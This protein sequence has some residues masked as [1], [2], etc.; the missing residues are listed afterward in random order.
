MD[1]LFDRCRVLLDV[2]GVTMEELWLSFFA[3]DGDADLLEIDAY[4]HG[5][6]TLSTFDTFV[7]DLTVRDHRC[8]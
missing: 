1:D 5:L 6:I 3:H 8:P 2:C 4:L 7:L